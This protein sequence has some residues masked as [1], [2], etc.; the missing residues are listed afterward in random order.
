MLEDILRGACAS[1][2]TS[3]SRPSSRPSKVRTGRANTA[4]LDGI[5]VDYYGVRGA[6]LQQMANVS[7]PEPPLNSREAWEKGR[8]PRGI[9]KAIRDSD[10]A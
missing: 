8:A 2:S 1:E 9:S 6:P 3:P 4:M 5:R 7:V 10:L